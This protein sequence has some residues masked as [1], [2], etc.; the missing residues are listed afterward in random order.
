MIGVYVHN[1]GRGHLHR[2]APVVRAL[3]EGDDDVTLL[4]TGSLDRAV[5]PP[6]LPVVHLPCERPGEATLSARR[7]A[8]TWIDR[9]RPRALWVDACPE[10]ALAARMTAT[11]LVATLT[12]GARS[13]EQ[14]RLGCR[15]ADVL[16]APW[17]AGAHPAAVARAGRGRV[18]E[19]GGLSR[20]ERREPGPRPR[21]RPRVVH[22]NS[23]TTV[24]D[25][26]FWRAVRS[27]VCRACGSDWL[28]V[29]GSDGRWLDDPWPELS[30]ADV[31]VTGAGQ[32]SVAD[33]ACADVPLVVVPEWRPHG[34]HAATAQ[35]LEGLP[36]AEVRSYG[37]GPTE[38]AEVVRR[39]LGRVADGEVAGIRERWRVD[40][41]AERAADVVRG[42]AEAASRAG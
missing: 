28:E 27:R 8:V 29:G 18:S 34:E 16:L 19:I 22:L 35:A 21:R 15:A 24:G 6:D 26:R 9:A 31:V 13:D 10:M 2:V 5:L 25:H 40:G 33:A 42:V 7:A 23:S 41:A 38:V 3:R 4:V 14:H 30:S 36:G 39:Q 17:P 11:P 20:F 37:D 12:P 1:R 32:S